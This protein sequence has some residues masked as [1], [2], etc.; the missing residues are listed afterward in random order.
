MNKE[1]IDAVTKVEPELRTP[2]GIEFAFISE[3]GHKYIAFNNGKQV[4]S[5]LSGLYEVG[6]VFNLKDNIKT[7]LP[8]IKVDRKDLKP[9]DIALAYDDDCEGSPFAIYGD[10]LSYYNVILSETEFANTGGRS[11]NLEA[12]SYDH[13]YKV[14]FERERQ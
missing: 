1:Q 4:L 12:E 6:A 9:G 10:R 14:D 2:D 7:N 11:V 3:T 8:L 13:W 5:E